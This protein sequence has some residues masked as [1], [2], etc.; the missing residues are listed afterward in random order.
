AA[1]APAAPASDEPAEAAPAPGP[2]SQTP[3]KLGD[4]HVYQYA[5]TFSKEPVTLTEQ[6]VGREGELLVVDFV[7]QEGNAMSALRVRMKPSGEVA[8]VFR[9]LDDGEVAATVAEYEAIIQRT[10]LVPDSNDRVLSSEKTSC[11]VGDEAV[12]CEVTTYQVTVGDRS[13][14]LTITRSAKLPGRDL[15]GDVVTDDGTVLYS[16]RLIERG[17]EPP[18][19]EALARMDRFTPDGP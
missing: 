4:F 2:T 19:V 12:D 15:G 9:I 8:S 13:A 11:L 14:K 16:A 5:G 3:R 10:A 6:V 1:P 18:V 17:N 7:L